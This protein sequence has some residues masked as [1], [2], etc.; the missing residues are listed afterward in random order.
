MV[1]RASF[2]RQREAVRRVE[3]REGLL[4]VVVSVGLGLAQLAFLKCADAHLE[5]R[6]EIAIAGPACLAYLA[7]VGALLWRLERGRRKVRPRCPQCGRRLEGLSER[8]ASATGRCDSCGDR[9]IEEEV[10][11]P[12]GG[13]D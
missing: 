13:G 11:P 10:K 6:R 2:E 1:T 12:T 3:R 5:H 8:V 9:V 7:L 4:L